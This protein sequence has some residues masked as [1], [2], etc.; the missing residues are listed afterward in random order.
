LLEREQVAQAEIDADVTAR[1]G[2]RP[3]MIA[4]IYARAEPA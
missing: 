1:A 3:R 2:R 4:A